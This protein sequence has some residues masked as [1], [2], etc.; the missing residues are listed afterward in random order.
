ML[1]LLMLPLTSIA[2]AAGDGVVLLSAEQLR[3]GDIRVLPIAELRLPATVNLPAQ[4]VVPPAQI[5]VLAAPLPA[6]VS[7]VRAAYGDVVRKGQLLA[8]LQGA[9]FLEVQREFLQ[10]QTQATLAAESRRRDETLF[11]DGIIAQSRLSTSRALEAQAVAQ[12]ADKRQALHL[13]GIDESV[14][15]TGPASGVGIR[16]PFDGVILEAPAQPGQRVDAMTPLFKLGRLSPL[17]LEMQA[18]AT[19]AAGLAPGDKVTVSGCEIA[20]KLTLIAPQMQLSS[21]SLLVRAE[22]TKPGTCIKPFQF[23]QAQVSPGRNLPAGA[24]RIP[25]TALARHQGQTWV[26]AEVP[27]GFRPVAVK[28]LDETPESATVSVELPADSRLAVKGVATL[29]AS[30]LGLGAGDGK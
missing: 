21:Q 19:Q 18:S 2:A 8:R 12:V 16:A 17:W 11:A 25:P 7:A 3:R 22:F 23:L 24:L 26:F 6:M 29:K 14:A 9:S 10:S 15:A 4:V 30:W 20:G 5:E 1:L 13:A 27:G 28:V